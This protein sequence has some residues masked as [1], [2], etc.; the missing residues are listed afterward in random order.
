[1]QRNESANHL[2][3]QW[4][5]IRA[6][7]YHLNYHILGFLKTKFNELQLLNNNG[8]EKKQKMNMVLKKVSLASSSTQAIS[9]QERWCIAQT[10]KRKYT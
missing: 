9:A 8:D 1:M 10:K 6:S 2:E 5:H 7:P 3:L 4:E